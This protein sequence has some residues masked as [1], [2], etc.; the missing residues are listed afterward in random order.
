MLSIAKLSRIA[1]ATAAVASASIAARAADT[2]VPST[3][4]KPLHAAVLQIGAKRTTSFY[5]AAQ[6]KCNVTLM[7]A[8]RFDDSATAYPEPLR[9]KVSVAGGDSARVDMVG[10]STLDV[11]CAPGAKTMAVSKIDRVAG[12]VATK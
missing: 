2:A 7:M 12:Y 6:D 9:I 8:D 11:Q 5:V 3:V 10:G 4:V 1:I